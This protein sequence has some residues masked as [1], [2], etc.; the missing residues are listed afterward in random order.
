M[1]ACSLVAMATASGNGRKAFWLATA[2]VM[3]AAAFTLW[4]LLASAYSSGQTILE[5][6]SDLSVRVAVAAPLLV[7]STAW[8]LLHVACR[9]DLTW[10]RRT[11]STL[12]WLLVVFSVIAGFSIGLFVLPGAVALVVAAGLTPVGPSTT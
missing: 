4:A 7:T 9:F 6:N 10:A 1:A 5:A 11:A 3:C 8:L 12:A 2:A